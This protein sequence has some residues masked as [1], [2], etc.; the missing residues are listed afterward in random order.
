MFTGDNGSGGGMPITLP[1]SV[2][3]LCVLIAIKHSY[4]ICNI[5]LY[6]YS[7]SYLADCN[8]LITGGIT[9]DIVSMDSECLKVGI[10]GHRSARAE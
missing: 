8:R 7:V 4:S 1:V 3:S 6:M 9:S 5:Q 10:G 2:S